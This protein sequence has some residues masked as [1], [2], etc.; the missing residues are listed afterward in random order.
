M[1]SLAAA[2]TGEAAMKLNASDNGQRRFILI[3]EGQDHDKFCRTVAAKRLKPGH[4]TA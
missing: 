4:A 3:E 2:P 1:P